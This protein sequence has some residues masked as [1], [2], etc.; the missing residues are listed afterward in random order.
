MTYGLLIIPFAAITLVVTLLSAIRPGFG[1]RVAASAIAAA[2]LV[3]LTAVFDNVM[4]LSGLFTYP[5]EHVSGLR[6]GVA[7]LEDFAYP[8]C[9]AFLVPALFALY[10]RRRPR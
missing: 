4:I 6:V 3:V 10:R 8:V 7:P 5:A 2:M 1:R 9:A